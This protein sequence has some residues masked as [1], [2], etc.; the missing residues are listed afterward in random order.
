MLLRD[1]AARRRPFHALWGLALLMFAGASFALFLGEVG[2][3][4]PGE[5]RAYWLLG[6]VLTVPYLA[7]GELYLLVRRPGVAHALFVL[8]LVGTA[9]AI[10]TVRTAT[11]DAAALA[12]DLPLGR[13]VF[14]D[15]TPAHR[16][17]QLYTYPAYFLLLGGTVWSALRIRG[18]AQMRERFLGTLL[19]AAGATVVAIGSGVG[20]GLLKSYV[21]ISLS[22]LGGIVLMFVGFLRAARSRPAG[23]P[24]ATT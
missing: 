6:A 14:G 11:I 15:G 23:D 9:V 17:A 16:F 5:F 4:T 12:H 8:L 2:G 7:M 20:A 3:W 19:V 13:E 10:A 21:F 18:R 1:Y 22:L 24:A